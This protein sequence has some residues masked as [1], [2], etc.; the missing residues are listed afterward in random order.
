ML[1]NSNIKKHMV[2]IRCASSLKCNENL[3]LIIKPEDFKTKYYNEKTHIKREVKHTY[4]EACNSINKI[5]KQ[6]ALIH[7]ALVNNNHYNKHSLVHHQPY[8]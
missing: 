5:Q 6:T 3:K 1:K 2:K 4:P 7:K 8:T